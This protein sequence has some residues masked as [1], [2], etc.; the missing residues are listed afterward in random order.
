MCRPGSAQTSALRRSRMP[1]YVAEAVALALPEPAIGRRDTAAGWPQL[2][3]RFRRNSLESYLAAAQVFADL[4]SQV[5]DQ[6]WESPGL[7]V[8]SLR[9]LVGHTSTAALSGVLTTLDKLS[10]IH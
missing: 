10:L 5:P 8:W 3:E 4:V 6:M 7:G 9:E 1:T 2:G